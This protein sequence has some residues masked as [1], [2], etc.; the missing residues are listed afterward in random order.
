MIYGGD[1]TMIMLRR[2]RHVPSELQ[3]EQVRA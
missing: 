2:I 3:N 1:D